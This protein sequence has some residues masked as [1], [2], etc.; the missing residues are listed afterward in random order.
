MLGDTI[1]QHSAIRSIFSD[2]VHAK[3]N[4][5]LIGIA[6]VVKQNCIGSLSLSIKGI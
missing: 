4:E 3:S 6:T 2:E 1:Q 5:V